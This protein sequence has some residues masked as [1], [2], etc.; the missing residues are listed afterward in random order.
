MRKAS[1]LFRCVKGALR[2]MPNVVGNF[3]TCTDGQSPTQKRGLTTSSPGHFFLALGGAAREKRPGGE[4]GG[5]TFKFFV[6]I[7]NGGES[8]VKILILLIGVYLTRSS[9]KTDHVT[10]LTR[11]RGWI[12]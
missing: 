10:T 5:L 1:R 9:N 7:V 11:K 12:T 2:N 3:L 6:T 8:S 4:V